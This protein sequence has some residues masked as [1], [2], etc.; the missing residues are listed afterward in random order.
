MPK[1]QNHFSASMSLDRPVGKI[2]RDVRGHCAIPAADQL[3]WSGTIG[4]AR[5]G[6]P[7]SASVSYNIRRS[8]YL[9][10]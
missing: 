10:K 2:R 7:R 5:P 8:R 4:D 6:L 9:E 3:E 1:T